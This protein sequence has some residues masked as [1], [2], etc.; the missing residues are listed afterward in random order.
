MWWHGHREFCIVFGGCSW[1]WLSIEWQQLAWRK[2]KSHQPKSHEAWDRRFYLL[3]FLF[4]VIHCVFLN[5]LSGWT[6][7]SWE[8]LIRSWLPK[9]VDFGA[10]LWWELWLTSLQKN[11]LILK[12]CIYWQAWTGNQTS[13]SCRQA[14]ACPSWTLPLCSRRQP[15]K[16]G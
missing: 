11:N 9:S 13:L 14:V 12:T 1:I 10:N 5:D 8:N 16:L 4:S 6:C 3:S 7:N 15:R 2:F